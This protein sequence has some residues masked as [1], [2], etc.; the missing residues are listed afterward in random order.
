MADF[1]AVSAAIAEAQAAPEARIIREALDC[2]K[3]GWLAKSIQDAKW[4]MEIATALDNPMATLDDIVEL[5]LIM[6]ERENLE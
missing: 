5:V 2:L 3:P 6:A 4:R 1:E